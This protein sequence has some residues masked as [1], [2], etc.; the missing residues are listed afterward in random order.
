VRER[1]EKLRKDLS[2][3]DPASSVACG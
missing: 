1:I 2:Y 3:P